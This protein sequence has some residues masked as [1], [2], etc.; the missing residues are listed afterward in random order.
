[1][2][3]QVEAWDRTGLIR[4]ISAVLADEKI[5]INA[6]TTRTERATHVAMIDITLG[7]GSLE[8]LSRLMHRIGRLPNIS[9]VRRKA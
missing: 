2:Q 9:S 8:Q 4:D 1:V 7:I 6:M 3:V 5:D